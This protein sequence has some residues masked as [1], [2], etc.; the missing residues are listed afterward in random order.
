MGDFIESGA[1]KVIEV[2]GISTESF[3]AAVANAVAKAAES[4]SGITG[5]EVE[6]F[7]ARVSDGKVVQ[8]KADVKLAFT[9][10]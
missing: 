1:I 4:I 5:V 3:E 2:I 7:S 9:V 10:R 6:H 8:Y